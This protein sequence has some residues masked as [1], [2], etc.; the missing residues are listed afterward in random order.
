MDPWIIDIIFCLS[1]RSQCRIRWWD[2]ASRLEI[3][4]VDLFYCS[5]RCYSHLTFGVIVFEPVFWLVMPVVYAEWFDRVKGEQ[6]L[7]QARFC[8]NDRHDQSENSPGPMVIA[9]L[10]PSSKEINPRRSKE[11]PIEDVCGSASKS[12]YTLCLSGR[13]EDLCLPCAR[14]QTREHETSPKAFRDIR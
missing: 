5:Q 4:R 10:H 14:P 8:I 2:P 3:F 7:C 1:A 9:S 12:T 11:P 6:L 13:L